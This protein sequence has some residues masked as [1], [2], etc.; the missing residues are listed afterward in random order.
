MV[1]CHFSN[2]RKIKR[3]LN[4]YLFFLNLYEKKSGN[5]VLCQIS[6]VLLSFAEYYP[7]IFE[8]FLGKC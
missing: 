2:P 4:H 5:R 1:D 6:F 7:N 3:I 8:L